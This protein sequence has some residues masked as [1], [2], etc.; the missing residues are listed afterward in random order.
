MNRLPAFVTG[1]DMQVMKIDHPRNDIG[2]FQLFEGGLGHTPVRMAKAISTG[3]GMKPDTGLAGRKQADERI[4][5]RC[6]PVMG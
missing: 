2:R 4:A 1:A 3:P 6:L 5:A